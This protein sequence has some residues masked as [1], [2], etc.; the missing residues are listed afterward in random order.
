MRLEQLPDNSDRQEFQGV[1]ALLGALNKNDQLAIANAC[2]LFLNDDDP[3]IVALTKA[4][5][6]MN[7]NYPKDELKRRIS[8]H[9]KGARLVLW[10]KGEQLLPAIYCPHMLCALYVR[11][12]FSA[13]GARRLAICPR[14]GEPFA[15]ERPNQ[16]YC[17]IRC[18]EAHR[19]ARFRERQKS[20]RN[21][22][23]RK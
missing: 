19:V 23:A 15:Q 6:S 9:L 14:C 18:R 10:Q 20:K 4:S 13:I 17:S 1:L 2:E 22:K 5:A 12:L 21:R 16:E 7:E 3:L 11:T 8:K